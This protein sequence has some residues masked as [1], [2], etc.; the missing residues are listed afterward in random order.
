MLPSTDTSNTGNVAASTTAEN[1][2]D[3]AVD[4]TVPIPR[5]S[6][7]GSTAS[8]SGRYETFTEAVPLSLSS[9]AHASLP[10]E[11]GVLDG[12]QQVLSHTLLCCVNYARIVHAPHQWSFRDLCTSAYAWEPQRRDGAVPQ[13]LPYSLEKLSFR[14]QYVRSACIS[15]GTR[16][17]PRDPQAALELEQQHD[18]TTQNA[19]ILGKVSLLYASTERLTPGELD[20][21][22][23]EDM[24][25][26][27][28]YKAV[29]E[30]RSLPATGNQQAVQA[31]ELSMLSFGGAV[32]DDVKF[33]ALAALYDETAKYVLEIYSVRGKKY[34]FDLMDSTLSNGTTPSLPASCAGDPFVKS[35]CATVTDHADGNQRDPQAQA[36]QA[37]E[38]AKN[39]SLSK[40]FPF[41]ITR[42]HLTLEGKPRAGNELT[43]LPSFDFLTEAIKANFL[44]LNPDP[45][46]MVT[47]MPSGHTLLLDPDMAG[48]IFVNGRYVTTWGLDSRIGSSGTALFGMDL[49]S[50]PF[51]H[52]KIVDYEVMKT[53]CAQMWHEVLV[54]ARLAPLNIASRLLNRLLYGRDPHM[55]S[56]KN[57]D[58]DDDSYDDD[59]TNDGTLQD[60]ATDCL[61][62]QVL[63]SPHYDKVGIAPK[64][65]A[66][67][68]HAEFGELAYPCQAHEMEWV[69]AA[70]PGVVP[71]LAPLRLLKILRRGGIMDV[72]QTA[73][74]LWFAECRPA[75]EGA[76]TQLIQS[77]LTLL[78]AAE[79]DDVKFEN[80]AFVSSRVAND[81]VMKNAVCRYNEMRHQFSVH[82]S[83]VNLAVADYGG[84]VVGDE[85]S[86]AKVRAY[87]LGMYV[88]KEHPDGELL[89][90]YLLRHNPYIER[91]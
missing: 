72:Q 83:F 45:P 43:N 14:H 48:R 25:P 58:D 34:K 79:C 29:V 85:V 71:V 67:R 39:S 12:I 49:H 54:D 78:R 56:N 13:D 81:V 32:D 36:D 42:I 64:A 59:D 53:A 70:L 86:D 40:K 17:L 24:P 52:G 76:E 22:D 16:G 65:L 55:G 2:T 90:R 33:G 68:F 41:A 37:E 61:E 89:P 46:A 66:T 15:L 47:C 77:A 75:K 23:V 30:Y 73:D 28:L 1:V 4:N 19:W 38:K 82:E 27:I 7:M 31:E 20:G 62:S 69:K 18:W 21:T 80:V 11:D 3:A 5:Q 91:A 74:N 44:M 9:M 87:L 35:L 63:S 84:P 60:T 50:I 51:W 57:S 26:T 8:V 10:L 88:A 6:S